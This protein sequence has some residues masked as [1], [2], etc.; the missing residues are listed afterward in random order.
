MSFIIK[1]FWISLTTWQGQLQRS[2]THNLT[3]VPRSMS[4]CLNISEFSVNQHVRIAPELHCELQWGLEVSWQWPR[5]LCGVL[6]SDAHWEICDVSNKDRLTHDKLTHDKC[7]ETGIQKSLG[8]E[9]M[10]SQQLTHD[11]GSW[12]ASQNPLDL[13]PVTACN[14]I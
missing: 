7:C 2:S 4:F 6:I 9:L 5:H 1:T 11:K 10:T 14:A 8:L 3:Q 12:N 13:Q